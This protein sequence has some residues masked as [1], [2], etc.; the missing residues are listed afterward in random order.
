MK[1]SL[2]EIFSG[3]T[4]DK[5]LTGENAIDKDGNIV[6][7]CSKNAVKWCAIGWIGHIIRSRHLEMEVF[8]RIRE[9]LS[10][11]HVSDTSDFLGY[12]FIEQLQ[13]LDEEFEL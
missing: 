9:K 11:K 6:N 12:K 3:L 13:L 8:S 5:F 10:I 1:T 7:P 4:P 2:A